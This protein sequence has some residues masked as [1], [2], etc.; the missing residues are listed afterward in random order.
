MGG[1]PHSPSPGALA[2]R[3][4]QGIPEAGYLMTERSAGLAVGTGSATGLPHQSRNGLNIWTCEV[5][6]AR[7]PAD[8]APPRG[9]QALADTASVIPTHASSGGW[10]D[11]GVES[12]QIRCGVNLPRQLHGITAGPRLPRP[13]PSPAYEGDL[14][15]TARHSGLEEAIP[16]SAARRDPSIPRH[17]VLRI[18]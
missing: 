11:S 6:R 18:S 15:L 16:R 3:Y 9:C 7:D 2:L 10:R 4:T 14:V 1:I 12:Y 17:L 5:S 13:H 8:C